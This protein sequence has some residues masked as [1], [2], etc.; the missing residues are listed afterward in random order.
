MKAGGDI[1]GDELLVVAEE[2]H[3]AL[4]PIHFFAQWAGYPVGPAD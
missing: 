1:V 4:P 2:L 3:P